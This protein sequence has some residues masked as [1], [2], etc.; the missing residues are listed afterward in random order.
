MTAFA[1][2]LAEKV[3]RYIELRR[4]LGFAFSKQASTLRA[5][6]RY[7]ERAELDGPLTR[8]M[9]SNFVLS[10]DGA[11]NSRAVR[12]GVLRRFCEYLAIYDP[13]TEALEVEGD[14]AAADTQ[15]GGVGFAHG[16]MQPHFAGNPP[17]GPDGGDADRAIGKHGVA[18]GR[19]SQA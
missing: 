8:T 3:E 9:T 2:F 1:G 17:H 14:P 13:R 18:L 7:V 16:G 5:F 6:I 19:S 15:R 4:S 11:A 10:F 12:H